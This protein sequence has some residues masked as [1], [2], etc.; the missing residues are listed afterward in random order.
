[1]A[2]GFV[3]PLAGVVVATAWPGAVDEVEIFIACVPEEGWVDMTVAPAGAF[4]IW[5]EASV[6]VGW[7]L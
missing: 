2:F 7:V 3:E 5:P 4:A 1:M 6:P